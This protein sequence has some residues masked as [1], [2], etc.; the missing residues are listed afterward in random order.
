MMIIIPRMMV[1]SMSF[2]RS[3]QIVGCLLVHVRAASTTFDVANLK[4]CFKDIE[5]ALEPP[6]PVFIFS[7]AFWS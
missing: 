4:A 5:L 1:M 3:G 6:L 7:L 2:E